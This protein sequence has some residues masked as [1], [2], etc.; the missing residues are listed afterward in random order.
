MVY[1]RK[2]AEITVRVKNGP[3]HLEEFFQSLTDK[4]IGVLAHVTYPSQAWTLVLLITD[5]PDRTRRVLEEKG[6]EYGC[7]SI[8]LVDVPGRSCFVAQAGMQLRSA[9]I[10]ILYSYV[11]DSLADRFVAVFK[12]TD[13]RGAIR[14]LQNAIP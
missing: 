13:D 14:I 6:F 2:E 8:V 9:G 12:T 3:G 10:G 1:A 5:N 11:S 4:G 7:D